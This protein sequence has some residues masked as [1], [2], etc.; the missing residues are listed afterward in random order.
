MI[1]KRQEKMKRRQADNTGNRNTSKHRCKCLRKHSIPIIRKDAK[2]VPFAHVDTGQGERIAK[3]LARSGIASRREAETMIAAGRI[4]LNGHVVMTP[5]INVTKADVIIVD[6]TPLPQVERTRLWLYHKPRGIVTTTRD[7][8]GRPTVFDS[9]PDN[10]PRV[11]SV[12]RL[13]I[14][15]EGLLLLTN[16]GGLSRILEL[17]STGWTRHYRVR[18]HGKI[19]QEELDMLKDGITVNGIFYNAVQASIEREKGSNI[20]L[21]L[22]LR[23]GKNREVKNILS[24]LGLMVTRLIR[25]SFG[26]FQL[27]ELPKGTVREICGRTL[28]DQLGK[29]LIAEANANFDAPILKPFSNN[30]PAAS[31]CEE[32]RRKVSSRRGDNW[33]LSSNVLDRQSSMPNHDANERQRG[34]RTRSSNVWMAPGARPIC[35]Q[36]RIRDQFPSHSKERRKLT[37]LQGCWREKTVQRESTDR[38]IKQDLPIGKSGAFSDRYEQRQ[39]KQKRTAIDEFQS[40][41]RR[42]ESQ[43]CEIRQPQQKRIDPYQCKSS[44]FSTIA[45]GE[46][47]ADRWR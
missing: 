12:G 47:D 2:S 19:T 35:R 38:I 7:P 4:I 26:P 40:N 24:A 1:Y 30:S 42:S 8:E 25:V 39:K 27:G 3:R 22:I 37:R 33:I 14:N 17:P 32:K 15:S 21:S 9:L 34:Y 16:D 10:M 43:L 29:R 46:R 5:A 6:G 20:W 11:L 31:H 44:R 45:R 18:I 41:D 23:E 28:R 13:D 36:P